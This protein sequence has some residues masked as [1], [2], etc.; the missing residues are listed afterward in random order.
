M[1]IVL[2]L[3]VPLVQAQR[4]PVEMVDE[5]AVADQLRSATSVLYVM[6]PRVR[7]PM[8]AEALRRA[9]VEND[10]LL[11]LLTSAAEPREASSFVLSLALLEDVEVRVAPIPRGMALV[12][13]GK[14][15]VVLEGAILEGSGA[16]FDARKT[17]ALRDPEVAYQRYQLFKALWQNAERFNPRFEVLQLK[18]RHE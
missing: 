12:G 9:V 3:L 11:L 13:Q 8:F 5:E 16:M 4:L 10:A 18:E 15:F 2:L 17:Y 7:N 1:V 6:L 14:D